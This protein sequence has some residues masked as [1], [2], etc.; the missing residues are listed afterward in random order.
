[1]GWW[2][3]DEVLLPVCKECYSHYVTSKIMDE[4][5]SRRIQCMGSD[6]NTIVD[7]KT[8]ELLVSKETL[9]RFVLSSSLSY[10]RV[11]DATRRQ[12]PLPPQPHL[13]RRR[14][15]PPLVPRT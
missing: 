14:L 13:R 5:E 1:M 6:C 9:V 11:T 2:E 8:I 7:E 15:A 12:L 10:Y 3:A 4:S